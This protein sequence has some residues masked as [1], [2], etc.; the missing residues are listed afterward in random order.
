MTRLI[1]NAG[2]SGGEYAAFGRLAGVLR[3]VGPRHVA[4][5]TCEAP[6]MY[7]ATVYRRPRKSLR[8]DLP[9]S[10]TLDPGLTVIGDWPTEEAAVEAASDMVAGL[11]KP[12]VC[13]GEDL[14]EVRRLLS[15][16]QL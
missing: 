3:Q 6:G 11:G 7:R 14:D 5:V 16:N 1:N 4:R 12:R 2:L 13:N 15:A 9:P 10:Y 8:L